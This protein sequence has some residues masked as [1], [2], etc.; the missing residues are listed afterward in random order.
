[1]HETAVAD[2][3]DMEDQQMEDENPSAK[4]ATPVEEAEGVRGA[5]GAGM[6][7]DLTPSAAPS[8]EPMDEKTDPAPMLKATSQAHVQEVASNIQAEDEVPETEEAEQDLTGQD[9]EPGDASDVDG[10]VPSALTAIPEGTKPVEATLEPM[11][12]LAQMRFCGSLWPE[13]I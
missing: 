8:P 12:V 5:Q 1:M 4:T 6:E 7:K 2:Q 10:A 3:E 13:P 9:S 11:E